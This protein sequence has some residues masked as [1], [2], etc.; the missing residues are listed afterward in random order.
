[1]PLSVNSKLDYCNS[2]SQNKSP[3]TDSEFRLPNFLI[4]HLLR[5]LRWLKIHECIEY[6]LL[7]L[8][9]KVLTTSQ[10]DYLHNLAVLIVE[11]HVRRQRT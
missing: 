10:P 1:M 11:V 2:L 7:S 8:T 5:S 9:Y 3:P 4:S 6:K